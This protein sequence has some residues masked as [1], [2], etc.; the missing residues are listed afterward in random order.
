MVTEPGRTGHDFAEP[1]LNKYGCRLSRTVSLCGFTSSNFCHVYC[2]VYVNVIRTG[3]QPGTGESCQIS[4]TLAS[5]SPGGRCHLIRN[6][7]LLDTK[8][9][10]QS[11]SHKA[12]VNEQESFNVRVAGDVSLSSLRNLASASG[13]IGGQI[14]E[15]VCATLAV[16]HSPHGSWVKPE[17]GPGKDHA[18]T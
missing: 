17:Q 1:D 5:A 16:S 3:L 14:A 13:C 8:W 18:V 4:F 2:P 6:I 12:Q 10:N 9:P 15:N 11:K 7:E